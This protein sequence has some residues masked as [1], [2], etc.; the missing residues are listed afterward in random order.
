MFIDFPR[1]ID[2]CLQSIHGR[3]TRKFY[4][5]EPNQSSSK[6]WMVW[7]HVYR[8]EGMLGCSQLT[9]ILR[10]HSAVARFHRLAALRKGFATAACHSIQCESVNKSRPGRQLASMGF[11]IVPIRNDLKA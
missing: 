1:F 4:E 2:M 3:S 9:S 5:D 7:I 8:C 10:C 11:Q 6:A